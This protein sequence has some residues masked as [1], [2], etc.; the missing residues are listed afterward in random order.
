MEDFVQYLEK[1]ELPN[2][3]VAAIGDPLLQKFLQLKY[4][5]VTSRRIDNWLLAFFE[6]QLET[7]NS[8]AGNILSMLQAIL[9]Y[10][11]YTKVYSPQKA[12][13]VLLTISSNCP[14]RV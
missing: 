13:W 5:E 11:R 8:A 9:E 1:I 12:L 7:S 2:Q 10:T 3:L 4:S 6:D 14:Q